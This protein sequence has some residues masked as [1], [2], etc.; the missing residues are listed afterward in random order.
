MICARFRKPA[1]RHSDGVLKA[2]EC[3]EELELLEL[4]EQRD[5]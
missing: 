2:G 5:T 4:I 3:Y 1:G